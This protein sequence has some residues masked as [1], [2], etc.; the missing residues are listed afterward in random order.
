MLTQETVLVNELLLSTSDCAL[1]GH[2]T[3]RAIVEH[4]ALVRYYLLGFISR[5]S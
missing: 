2:I 4:M 1:L 5:K 3:E